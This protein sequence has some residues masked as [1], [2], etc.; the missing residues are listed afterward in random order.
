IRQIMKSKHIICSVP[1]ERKAEAVKN[2]LEQ[3]VSNLYPASIL[4]EHPQC[5]LYLDR[6]AASLL[7]AQRLSRVD[8]LYQTYQGLSS[9]SLEKGARFLNLRIYAGTGSKHFADYHKIDSTITTRTD[10][11][12]SATSLARSLMVPGGA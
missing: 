2:T 8:D 12:R 1:D 10:C 9:A 7:D 3:P 11:P 6:P 4:R 5:M